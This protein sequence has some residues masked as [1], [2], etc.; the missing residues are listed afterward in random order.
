MTP[1][2]HGLAVSAL[3]CVVA[4]RAQA[5]VAFLPA[6]RD[7]AVLGTLES[8]YLPSEGDICFV[9]PVAAPRRS[10]APGRRVFSVEASPEAEPRGMRAEPAIPGPPPIP[11]SAQWPD[12]AGRI[13]AEDPAAGAASIPNPWETRARSRRTGIDMAF[14]CGG[15]I[16]GGEAGPTAIVNGRI[17]RRGDPLGGFQVSLVYEGGA[18][19]ERRGAYF[20]LPR[21]RTTTISMRGP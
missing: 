1:L 17:V 8:A 16:I 18:V 2:L 10:P 21:G 4:P 6:S 15:T 5:Q 13:E 19:L 12:A 20:V 7:S 14:A 3:A 11:R 9:G